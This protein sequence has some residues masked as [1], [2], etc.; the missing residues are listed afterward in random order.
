MNWKVLLFLS[1]LGFG[2]FQHYQDREVIHGAGVVAQ[3]E[4]QQGNI[5]SASVEQ[6]NGYNLTPLATFSVTARVLAS[7]NYYMGREA[8]LAPVD[9]AL[10]WG[11]MS[12]EAVLDKIDISQGN[13]FYYWRVDAFPIP[14]KDIETHS[15]NM[16]MIPGNDS[17]EKRLKSVRVGQVIQFEG[18]LVEAKSDD[19]WRWKSSLT[20][21]D[22]GYGA[23]EVVLVKKISV[24]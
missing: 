20:R 11:P 7:K 3:D 14:R 9:L 5:G 17:V 12:D 6:V 2:A 10:G 19:G 13:R 1:V 22:T 8:D 23:C 4:P 24:L 21:N 16:H 18:Y 15:A